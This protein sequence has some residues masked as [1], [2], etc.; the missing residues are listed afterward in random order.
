ME[1]QMEMEME[2]GIGEQLGLLLVLGILKIQAR[3]LNFTPAGA[4]NSKKSVSLVGPNDAAAV[5]A[6]TPP[7]SRLAP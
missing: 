6:A 7:A 4:M 5:A 1:M 3:K 2:M